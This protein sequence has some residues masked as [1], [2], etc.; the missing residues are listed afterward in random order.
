MNKIIK[1]NNE[2]MINKKILKRKLLRKVLH[3][4]I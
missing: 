2:R 1:D 4:Q 3:Y